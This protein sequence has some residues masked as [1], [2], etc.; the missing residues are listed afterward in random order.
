MMKYLD[1]DGARYIVATIQ[2][3]LDGKVSKDGSKVLST[4]DYTTTEKNKLAGIVANA[5]KVETSTTIGNLKING[6]EKQIIPLMSAASSSAAGKAGLVPAPAQNKHTSF[7][8]GDG[9][10]VIPTNTTYTNATTSKDGLMSQEDKV[11]LDSIKAGDSAPLANGVANAGTSN[12][13]AREDHKHPLQTTISGNAA[14]ATKLQTART[15]N[16]VNFDGTKNITIT[17][18]VET[19]E[20]ESEDLDD[21]RTEGEYYATDNNEVTSKPSSVKGFYL[22]IYRTGSLLK[23]QELTD[24]NGEKYIRRWAGLSWS[25]WEK[26]TYSLATSSSSGLLSSSDYIKLSK[27]TSTEMGYLDGVTSSIQT[28]LNSKANTSNV[29]TKNNTTSYT[30][31][32]DYHP[33]TKKYVDENSGSKFDGSYELTQDAENSLTFYINIPDLT[34]PSVLEGKLIHIYVATEMELFDNQK[35]IIN[36]NENNYMYFNP[37]HLLGGEIYTATVEKAFQDETKYLFNF[38]RRIGKN[39]IKDSQMPIK[40]LNPNESASFSFSRSYM[41]ERW[42]FLFFTPKATGEPKSKMK[43]E[44]LLDGTTASSYTR[45]YTFDDEGILNQG[46]E[47]IPLRFTSSYDKKKI[48]VKAT[49]VSGQIE[50]PS[51]YGINASPYIFTGAFIETKNNIFGSSEDD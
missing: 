6:T 10:W 29:L 45:E 20:L 8:R 47:L 41:G 30:P 5:T 4:N 39:I 3:L 33:A 32:N 25:S 35:V 13:Y 38:G 16:G 50:F 27:V 9:T 1:L 46:T 34:D 7:L 44:I 2:N 24:N 40:T 14:T 12:A 36:N 22:K 17:A 19:T 28:Q 26:I 11:K 21:I 43:V 49:C 42:C 48:E 31:T 18:S 37:T 15:I 51:R 23:T